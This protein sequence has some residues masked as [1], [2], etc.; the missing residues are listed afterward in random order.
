MSKVPLVL[1]QSDFV[2]SNG[3]TVKETGTHTVGPSMTRQEFAE[4]CD[5][6][7]IMAKYDGYLSDPLRSMR[8][9]VYVDFTELPDTL[10]GTMALVQE[11][12]DAFYR[13]PAVVRREFDN[14]PVAFA[15]FAADP[16]NVG[17]MR[18]WGLAAPEKPAER[19]MKVE[20]VS[21]EPPAAAPVGAAPPAGGAK[22]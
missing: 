8:T 2:K 19:P 12:S 18:E 3:L 15:D 17:R 14:D 13:L 22:S 4:D 11:A 5:I 21:S 1:A 10:M 20:V 9:P 16:A 7:T 6:N